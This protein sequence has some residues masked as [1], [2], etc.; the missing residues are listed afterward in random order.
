MSRLIALLQV[1]RVQRLLSLEERRDQKILRWMALGLLALFVWALFAP[2]DRIV[3]AEGRVIAAGRAQTI[4]HLEG[5]IVQE[6]LVREGQSVDAGQVL[7]R[8]SNVQANTEVQQGVNNLQ[9]LKARQARL[10]AE[11]D[12]AGNITFGDDVDSVQRELERSTFRERADRMRSE[13]AALRQQVLQRQAEMSESNSRARNLAGEQELAR[14]Q[15][16]LLDGLVKKGAASQLE[17]LEAQGRTERLTSAYSEALASIPRLQ[18]AIGEGSSRLAE[19][20]AKFRADARAELSQIN[21]EIQRMNLAVSGTSDKLARTEVT[22]SVSGFINRLNFNTI[23]GVIKAGE[24]LM[25]ITPNKGPLSVEA[26]VRPDDRASL[27][28]GLPTRV[29]IGAYDYAVFGALEGKLTE[30][31]SDTVPDENGV[32]SYRVVIEAGAAKGLLAKE[33]ILPGMTARADVVLGQRTVMSYL[34]SPVMRFFTQTMREP[35]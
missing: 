8:L 29:M 23:G 20:S 6:I 30:V 15:S 18:A 10:Q 4:Q 26:R 14:K 19:S 35:T 24:P 33:V 22:A 32:R 5:G 27:R 3:R 31:S 16:A 17:L 1:F 7:M 2:I 12:G 25:E 21:T 13:Q 34:L 28:P 9:S 11:A